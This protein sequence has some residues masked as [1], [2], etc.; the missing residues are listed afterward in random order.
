M[1]RRRAQ[2]VI[3]GGG[4]AGHTNPGIAVAQALVE[5]GLA[6]DQVHFV[7]GQRG[8]EGSLVAAAGFSIDLLAGRGIQRRVTMANVGAVGSLVIGLAQGFWLVIR[9][10]PRVVLCLGGYAAFAVSLAS[11][12]LRVPVVVTE[13]NARA[14]A[15]NRFIGRWARSCA[16]PFP[17]TDL[18]HGVLTGNPTLPAVVEAVVGGDVVAARQRLGLPLDRAVVAVWSGSLGATRVNTAVR[19]LAERWA[20]RSDIAL[21]HVVGRRDWASFAALPATVNAGALV[22]QLVEYEDQM[23]SLLVAAD[24]AV[25]R[26]GASTV[27]EICIAGLPALLV[28]LPGAPRDHQRANA[29]ELAGVGGAIVVADSELDAERLD[30]LLTPL[31][32]DPARRGVMAAAASSVARPDAADQVAGLVLTAGRIELPDERPRSGPPSTPPSAPP[33]EGG[34]DARL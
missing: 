2:V 5:L 26:S 7:G 22:Y 8:N 32:E 12:V 18:P 23:P 11:I 25:C 13:Q 24:V 29:E 19:A 14:S 15:V 21:R 1:G 31:L 34:L 10:R 4:T 3:T 6:A 17:G 9:R 28:P 16:L 30:G 33:S 20:D 27:A